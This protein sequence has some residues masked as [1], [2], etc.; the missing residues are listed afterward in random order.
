MTK[1]LNED[2]ATVT[3]DN[4]IYSNDVPTITSGIVVEQGQG[5]LERGTL[6]AKKDNGKM[7]ILGTDTHPADCVLC[8]KVDATEVDAETVAYIQGHFSIDELKVKD[9]YEITKGDEDLLRTKNILLG[10]ALG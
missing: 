7:V 10:K 2:V 6:L 8:D 3:Y 9:G 5:I 4:L 1:V